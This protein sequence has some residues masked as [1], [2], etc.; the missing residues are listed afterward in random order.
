[1]EL[2]PSF[3]RAEDPASSAS[4][5]NDLC[6]GSLFHSIEYELSGIINKINNIDNL[7]ESEIKDIIVRQHSMILNYDLF[8][9]SSETRAQAQILFTN[10]RFLKCF[11][12]VIRLLQ[13]SNHEKVCINKLAYDYYITPNN[14]PEISNMLYKLSTEVNGREVVVLSGVIGMNE[15]RILSMIR[16]STFVEEKAIHRV[17]TYIIKCDL[18]LSVKDVV[19][20]YYY[21]FERFG[22]LFTYAMMESKPSNLSNFEN[23]K[24]DNISIA[25]LEMLNSLTSVDIRKVLADYAFTLKMVKTNTRVR[26]AIKS[27]IRF[28]R[29]ISILREIELT[30]NITIP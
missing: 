20:I 15:A 2:F 29:I 5:L 14:D 26:F 8:L 21:L 12:D 30:E 22:T 7:N 10:K 1:M 6:Q 25:L 4:K 16:N 3:T 13:L 23:K 17:N 24:F 9:A 27:A 11:L 19:N 28:N 18:D